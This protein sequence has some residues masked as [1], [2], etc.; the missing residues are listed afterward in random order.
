MYSSRHLASC[1]PYPAKRVPTYS[2]DVSST[3]RLGAIDALQVR[4]GSVTSQGIESIPECSADAG[5]VTI[6]IS[7]LPID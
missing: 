7:R 5:P 1:L 4:C 3:A 2:R 6:F